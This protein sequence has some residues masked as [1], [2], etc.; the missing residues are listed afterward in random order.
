[1]GTH[2]KFTEKTTTTVSFIHNS[3]THKT[4]ITSPSQLAHRTSLAEGSGGTGSQPEALRSSATIADWS[5]R[6]TL[7]Y[8]SL[9]RSE[10]YTHAYNNKNTPFLT[11]PYGIFRGPHWFQPFFILN[12]PYKKSK[13]QQLILSSPITSPLQPLLWG[14]KGFLSINYG[15]KQ[16]F[17]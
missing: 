8:P 7:F 10:K 12:C 6:T 2:Q 1:M 15:S 16:P 9:D 4:T 5:V 3:K 11:L 14:W 17:L 13:M